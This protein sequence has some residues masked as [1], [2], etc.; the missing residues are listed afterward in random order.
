MS[1]LRICHLGKF[2]PPAPGGIETH[3]RTLALAQAARG[4]SVS[5]L[6]INHKPGPTRVEKDGPVEITRFGRAASALKL[7]VCPELPAALR[8]IDAD[9]LHLQV[10]NPTMLLALLG[11]RRHPPLV[12]SYQSDV[13]RQRLRG[14]MFRP[15]EKIVY[16]R[17]RA[18][19]ASS[20]EY[21]K[22]SPFLNKYQDRLGVLANGI[23]LAPYLHPSV[24]RLKEAQE[25]RQ[26]FSGPLWLGCGRMVY[27][28]GFHNAI[29]A[30]TRVEGTLILVGD[31][32]ERLRLEQEAKTLGLGDRVAF[33]GN[34]PHYLDLVPYY[35]AADAFWFPSN[36]RSEAFGI[37]Q[38]EAMA[39]GCPVLNTAIP[40]SGASWVS[41]ND[42]E[43]LTVAVDD[44]VALADAANRL[45]REPGLRD[46]LA[47]AARAR[48]VA[49][50][51]HRVMAERSLQIY[52]QVLAGKARGTTADFSTTPLDDYSGAASP[53]L[54]AGP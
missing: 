48:A 45:L 28:K 15:V 47:E 2:Y 13:V 4:A 46:R 50:F 17:V 29:R 5:V 12:V 14:A 53:V 34:L 51:D 24:E 37:V 20:P 41:R 23:D 1:K 19:L 8:S 26:R 10:P 36:A 6:C 40:H 54:A 43:G 35:L 30:L 52:R 16:R 21:A 32:P 9:V 18:I 38:V 3:V 39:C 7:D 25:I 42:R 44:P 31:G 27:Y 49:E 11:V 33:L 22:G